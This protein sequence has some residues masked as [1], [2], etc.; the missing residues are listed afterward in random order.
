M[1][2]MQTRLFFR[3]INPP[4]Q[5][6]SICLLRIATSCHRVNSGE[7]RAGGNLLE[8]NSLF[9]KHLVKFENT[10]G[11]LAFQSGAISD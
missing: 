11:L 8:T 2:P 10:A 3:M 5:L 9:N 1:F 4:I 7:R 6:V